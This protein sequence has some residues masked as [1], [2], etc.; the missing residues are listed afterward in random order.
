MTDISS[1]ALKYFLVEVI[2]VDGPQ[3]KVKYRTPI[4]FKD[5]VDEFRQFIDSIVK[6]LV[7]DV[8][9]NPELLHLV[10]TYQVHSHLKCFRK[11][12]NE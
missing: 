8:N 4:L 1:T 3:D 7:P 9:E 10:T 2:I 5:T 11:C 12:K 6:A